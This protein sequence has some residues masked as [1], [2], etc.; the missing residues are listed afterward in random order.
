VGGGGVA[1]VSQKLYIQDLIGTFP[2]Y[3][4]PVPIPENTIAKKL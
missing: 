1:R 2:R 3:Y 4:Q